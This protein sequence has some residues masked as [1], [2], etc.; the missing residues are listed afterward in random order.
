ML[1]LVS[2]CSRGTPPQDAPALGGHHCCWHG[3]TPAHTTNPPDLPS[4]R[5][6]ALSCQSSM[7]HPQRCSGHSPW[8]LSGALQAEPTPQLTPAH[9]CRATNKAHPQGTAEEGSSIPAALL[10]SMSS[11]C[12]QVTLPQQEQPVRSRPLSYLRI[13]QAD[14]SSS[15][16]CQSLPRQP[17]ISSRTAP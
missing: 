3:H 5:A 2:A 12:A 11:S 9:G 10:P 17:C 8:Q 13:S 16:R 7:N 14:N 1:L 15:S 6:M 4:C